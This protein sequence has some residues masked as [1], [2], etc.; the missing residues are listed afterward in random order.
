MQGVRLAREARVPPS[1]GHTAG[2]LGLVEAER[3]LAQTCSSTI[4]RDCSRVTLCRPQTL[5]RERPGQLRS[6]QT[7]PMMEF[8]W[9]HWLL[10][11]RK[12]GASAPHDSL[13][14]ICA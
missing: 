14:L 5:H 10:Q 9:T 4:P 13:T 12:V 11:L 1:R 7:Q 8:Q 6:P 3:S 2:Q